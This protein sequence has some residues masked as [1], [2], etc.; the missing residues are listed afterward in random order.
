[1]W[2]DFRLLLFTLSFFVTMQLP[3]Q[4][5]TLKGNVTS[6]SGPIPYASITIKGT[7]LGA[8]AAED[9]SF[10]I[11]KVPVGNLILEVRSVGYQTRKLEVEVA[12]GIHELEVKLVQDNLKLSDVVVSASRYNQ[13]RKESPVIVNVLRPEIMQATQSLSVSE[14]LSYQPGVRVEN[15]CQNCGMTQVRLNGLD[16]AYSQILI[17]SRPVFSAL[18]QRLWTGS[19]TLQHC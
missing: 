15:N 18:K 7:N 3:G 14:G 9:G 11:Y 4:T 6:E 13:D 5:A 17:D 1:M 19:D 2:S 10:R 12:K 8:V 16:G